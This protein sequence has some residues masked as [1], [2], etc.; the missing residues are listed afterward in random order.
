MKHSL[1]F[2]VVFLL[3]LSTVLLNIKVS[4]IKNE[5]A[6]INKEIDGLETEKTLLENYIQSSLNFKEIEKKALKMGL[7]Y[8]KNVIELRIYNGK[9]AE[10]TKENYYAATLER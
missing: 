6:K 3:F 7:V 8:P 5:I 2:L 10:I 1:V 9:L 4:A